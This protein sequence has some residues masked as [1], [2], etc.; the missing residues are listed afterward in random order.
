MMEE[1]FGKMLT[2]L[3]L[4]VG[5]SLIV[6]L[7]DKFILGV[8]VADLSIFLLFSVFTAFIFILIVY[9]MV[10]IPVSYTHLDVYKRQVTYYNI[11]WFVATK[12]LAWGLVKRGATAYTCLLYT[13]HF[14]TRDEQAEQVM[15]VISNFSFMIGSPHKID[16]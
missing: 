11:L 2:F 9:T 1:Y 4:A 13:S 14:S 15:P 12:N 6:A 16:C 10:S 3:T 8:T 5:Q 7:G